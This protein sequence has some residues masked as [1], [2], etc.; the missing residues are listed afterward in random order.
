MLP[1][2]TICALFLALAS[3]LANEQEFRFEKSDAQTVELMAEF[4]QW[5]GLFMTKQPN[6]LW[7]IKVWI[8]P[9]TYRYKFLVDEKDWVFDPKTPGRKTVDGLEFFDS[10]VSCGGRSSC[11]AMTTPGLAGA[12][13]SMYCE[14]AARQSRC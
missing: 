7:T 12:R 11:D 9:G 2:R 5:K 10:K 1:I 3:L 4:N 14:I 6:G 8:P 13:P